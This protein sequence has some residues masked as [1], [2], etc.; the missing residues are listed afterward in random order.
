MQINDQALSSLNWQLNLRYQEMTRQ[1]V[2]RKDDKIYSIEIQTMRLEFHLA[3]TSHSRNQIEEQLEWKHLADR[4]MKDAPEMIATPEEAAMVISD[5]GFYGVPK[6][7]DRLAQFVI[8]GANNN[9]TL[10]RAGREGI[11]KGFEEA[12]K[13]WGEPLPEIAYKTLE[14]ALKLVDDHLAGLGYSLLNVEG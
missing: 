3:A 1:A 11:L 9:E 5:E 7:S 14:R 13:A 6:T 8:Q 12:E 10:L 4:L 2:V